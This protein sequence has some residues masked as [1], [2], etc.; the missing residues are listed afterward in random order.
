MKF[1]SFNLLIVLVL[2]LSLLGGAVIV[3]PARAET[4]DL[5]PITKAMLNENG[6]LNLPS[7]FSGS[8]NLDGWNVQLDAAH[9]PVFRPATL[10]ANTWSALTDK[11]LNDFVFALA[12]AGTDLYVGGWFT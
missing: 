9:G 3:T 6:T 11:G 8:L 7:G 4:G 5:L 12:V 10:P 2:F 1:R